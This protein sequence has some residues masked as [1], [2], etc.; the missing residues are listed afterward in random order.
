MISNIFNKWFCEENTKNTKESYRKGKI[1]KARIFK[2]GKQNMITLDDVKQELMQDDEFV[3][4]YELIQPEMDIIR[5][6][7]EKSSKF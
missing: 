1:N 3:K 7:I 4:E 5:A 6:I 2:R